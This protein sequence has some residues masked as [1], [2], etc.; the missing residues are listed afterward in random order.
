[1]R[2]ANRVYV[3]YFDAE[4]FQT[5]VA[6][7]VYALVGRHARCGGISTHED[8]AQVFLAKTQG[9]QPPEWGAFAGKQVE[10]RDRGA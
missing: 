6:T 9:A 1:M 3:Q 10:K 4:W 2:G 7:S 8:F 5:I